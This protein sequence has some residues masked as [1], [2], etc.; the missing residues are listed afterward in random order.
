MVVVP[1]LNLGVF[2]STN[3]DTGRPLVSR[4][5][6]RIVQH[7]YAD[8]AGLPARPARRSWPQRRGDFAGYY[9]TTRRAY[10][11]LEGFVDQLIGGAEV[12]RH[13]TTAGWSPADGG[14]VKTWVPEGPLERGPLHRHRRA[15]SG[16][17]STCRTGGRPR[18]FHVASGTQVLSSARRSGA[19]RRRWRCWPRLAAAAALA[20]LAGVVV[21]NR[22]EFRENQ[23][24]SRASLV[25][26]IQAVL[27]LAGA[28]RCFG[29]WASKTGDQAR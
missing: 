29:L 11:G 22:R 9:L 6:D 20:T 13:A 27:W 18:A 28:R 24:Q 19:S 10:S 12:E 3:T 1:D 25:Q 2:I 26:N 15:P 21:R 7:F 5:P 16:S 4:L 14:G 8:A 17:P 23:V